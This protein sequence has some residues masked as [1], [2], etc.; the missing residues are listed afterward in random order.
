MSLISIIIPIYNAGV[1][2]DE[3]LESVC[4]QTIKDIE[5]VLIN[6]GSTDDSEEKCINWKKRDARIKVFTQNNSGVSVARN[7]GIM[8]SNS[9]LITFIDADDKISSN[10]CEKLLEQM[11]E[12]TE[13]V[14]LGMA[15]FFENAITPIYHRLNAGKYCS[16]QL[17]KIVIDDG[18]MSGFTFQSSCATL[19]RKSNIVDNNIHFNENIK[20]NEDGLFN[21]EYVFTCK[22]EI[23]INFDDIIY[24]YRWNGASSSNSVDLVSVAFFD[25]LEKINKVLK[26]MGKK[27]PEYNIAEQINKRCV[28]TALSQLRYAAKHCL[29][30]NKI[31]EIT[32]SKE[33][34]KGLK[35]I[36]YSE[37]SV[38]K[39]LV[40]MLL[41]VNNPILIKLILRFV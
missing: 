31:K 30:T 40:L 18:T 37:L 22:N 16:E 21:V 4:K 8:E 5:I 7:R 1:C 36:V 10:Y 26:L 25:T 23:Y 41:K 20:F 6:D 38:K 32:A 24:F 29:T 14:V 9:E 15:R 19:Y 13:M 17:K 2:I 11:T 34:K 27:Y 33:Y 28:A 12:N 35:S 3:C 39:F